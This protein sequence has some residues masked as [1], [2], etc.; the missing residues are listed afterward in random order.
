VPAAAAPKASRF[1]GGDDALSEIKSAARD[2]V[3]Q[4]PLGLPVASAAGASAAPAGE[5]AAAAGAADAFDARGWAANALSAGGASPSAAAADPFGD[6]APLDTGLSLGPLG[7]MGEDLMML[8]GEDSLLSPAS[9][10]AGGFSYYDIPVEL[11][12]GD[13]G[14]GFNDAGTNVAGMA[15]VQELVEG[16]LE[17]RAAQLDAEN[18][19][20]AW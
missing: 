4:Q 5:A 16:S 11:G 17:A 7:A 6:P 13:S 12:D 2:S 1:H 18:D 15:K 10:A 20:M 8:D 3:E 9:N 19:G 14:E